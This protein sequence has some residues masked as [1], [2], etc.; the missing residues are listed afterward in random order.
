MARSRL[1][2]GRSGRGSA[3]RRAYSALRVEVAA[4][5]PLKLTLVPLVAEKAQGEWRPYRGASITL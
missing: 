5:T 1:F 4:G 2:L 3:L